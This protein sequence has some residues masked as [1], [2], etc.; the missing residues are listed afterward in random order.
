MARAG[1]DGAVNGRVIKKVGSSFEV[2]A[3]ANSHLK[4]AQR[5]M[6]E[7]SVDYLGKD[8]T[9]A[10]KLM[11][12]GA[13][14]FG[15]AFSQ[16]IT[17]SLHLGGEL[18]LVAVPG[19]TSIGQIGARWSAGRDVFNASLSR[20]PDPKVGKNTHET[21]LSY[22]RKVSERLNLGT[23]FK[24]S[25]PEKESGLQL[26][27]EYLFTQARIQGLLDT[28]GKVSCCVSDFSGFGFNGTFVIDPPS[29]NLKLIQRSVMWGC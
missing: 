10:G 24:F 2:K 5:N 15:G 19:V 3:S 1:L 11:W 14:L 7:L 4:D 9:M 6:H 23:E 22:S 28:D 20:M 13:F 21:K 27:Y 25:H 8:W 17:P 18:T 29:R 12:Q 16:K 26:A